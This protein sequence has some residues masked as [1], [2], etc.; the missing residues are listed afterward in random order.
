MIGIL[1]A[2]HHANELA[3]AGLN[4]AALELKHLSLLLGDE[5]LQGCLDR[6]GCLVCHLQVCKSYLFLSVDR[7]DVRYRN[8]NQGE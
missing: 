7:K 6:V 5:I 2:H 8:H 3:A 1:N 4:L